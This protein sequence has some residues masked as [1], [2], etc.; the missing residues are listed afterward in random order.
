MNMRFV[1][2]LTDWSDGLKEQVHSKIAVPVAKTLRT[3]DFDLSFH[4]ESAPEK[5]ER[6]PL[7]LWAVLQTFDGR[8]NQVVRREGQN[9]MALI[10]DVASGLCERLHR[11]RSA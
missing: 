1:S 6:H 11:V 9:L 4:L 2:T 7:I 10:H 5:G 3:S 8:G